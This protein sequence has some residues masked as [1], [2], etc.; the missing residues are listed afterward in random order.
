MIDSNS[1]CTSSNEDE[2]PFGSNSSSEG[3]PADRPPKSPSSKAGAAQKRRLRTHSLNYSIGENVQDVMQ[4][5]KRTIYTAGRPPWYDVTGELKE[6]FVIGICGGSASGKTTVAK[7]I[8]QELDVQWISLL[9]MDSFY[10]VLSEE[11]H[12]KANAAEYNF[13]HP[14]A[15]DIDLLVDTLKRLKSGKKVEIPLYNFSTHSRERQTKILYGATVVIFEGILAFCDERLIELCDM[16]VFV[17]TDPDIRLARRLSRD[18]TE[19]SRDLDSV[20]K[21]Y[22]KFVKPSYDHCIAPTMRHADVIVP[23]GGQ[24]V[25]AVT[26]IVQHVHNQLLHRGF[27]LRSKLA[28]DDHM[29]S[30]KL[31]D[32][33]HIIEQTDQI[34]GMHALIRSNDTHRDDF[35]FYSKRLMRLLIEDVMSM[36]PFETVVVDT[37]Q[38]FRYVGKR[39]NV[40]QIIGVSVL[41]AG[42]V[43][44]PAL[45]EVCKDVRIGKILIQTNMQTHEPELH[46]LRL[47]K[48]IKGQ[49]VI[50]M[51]PTVATGAAAIMAIRVLLDHDVLEEDI[52][53]VS[54]IMAKQGVRN[55]G[56]AFPKMRICTTAVDKVIDDNFHIIPGIGNFGD[57]YFGTGPE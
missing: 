3:L 30:E 7:K 50:L 37:P 54:L 39:L 6:A 28:C 53:I 5:G 11:Q 35:I 19:R 22:S 27:P 38:K 13:D 56:Y 14:D 8:I 20:L 26:L 10:K 40:K 42:E 49:H 16:K 43:M 46:Y 52:T 21:Q 2:E 25:V 31:P 47:P 34:Q 55:I 32:N 44:E 18:I 12:D 41:R 15:F 1:D 23:R 29:E 4:Q 57:R 9:S 51:D 33:L 48:D 36:L 24:N 45:C 17:D